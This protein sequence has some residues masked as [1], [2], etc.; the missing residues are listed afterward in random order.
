MVLSEDG[1]WRVLD[2]GQQG[3]FHDKSVLEG[4]ELGDLAGAASP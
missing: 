2:R 4:W 1:Q 3:P